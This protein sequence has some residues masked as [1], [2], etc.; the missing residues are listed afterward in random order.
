VSSEISHPRVETIIIDQEQTTLAIL[1]G[2]LWPPRGAVIEL[3]DPNR[4]A[5]VQDVRMRLSSTHASILIDVLDLEDQVVERVV[6]G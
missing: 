2:P 6:S 3:G 1:D 5:V 4:D